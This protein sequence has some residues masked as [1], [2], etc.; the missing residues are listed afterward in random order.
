MISSHDRQILR[1]LAHE[2]A[3]LAALPIQAERRELWKKH[4]SLQP[5]RPMILVFPEGA[6]EELLTGNDLLCEG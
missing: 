1:N 6:W 4:N 5:T 3:E 2:V